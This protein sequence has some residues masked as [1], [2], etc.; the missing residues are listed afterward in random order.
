MLESFRQRLLRA[1]GS[2]RDLPSWREH[3]LQA[4]L[5]LMLSLGALVALPSMALAW[6]R[7]LYPVLL[8]D[9]LALLLVGG[10]RQARQLSFRTRAGGLLVLVHLLGTTLLWW[11][12]LVGQAYLMTVPVLAIL[13][14]SGRA[15]LMSLLANV[16]TWLFLG[17]AA[18]QGYGVL[19]LNLEDPAAF[20]VIALN[21]LL[22]DVLMVSAAAAMLH[23]LQVVLDEHH[24]A[25]NTFRLMAAQVPGV[26]FRLCIQGKERHFTYVSPGVERLYGLRPEEVLQDSQALERQ[27]HP[28]DRDGLQTVIASA[29][30]EMQPIA[31]EF[32]ILSR[33][34]QVKWVELTTAPPEE[35]PEGLVRMGLIIDVTER[36]RAEAALRESEARWKLA[37]ECAG[38]GVW[39]WDLVTGVEVF[40]DRFREM[41]GL[42][43]VSVP[44]LAAAMDERTHPDDRASMAQARADHL[45]GRTPSYVHEHRILCR[46]GSW[47][48]VLSRGMVIARDAQGRPLRMIG[49]H[50]DI[51][52][53]KQSEAVIWRQ[54]HFDTL[55]G[56]PNRHMLRLRLEEEVVRCLASGQTLALMLIDLDRFKEVNDTLGHGHGD[57]LLVE[58]AQRISRCVRQTDTVARMGGDEFTVLLPQV[59]TQAQIDDLAHRIIGRLREPFA[60]GAERVHVTAS[61]GIALA[62]ADAQTIDDLL[63][64]AD[65]A[66]YVAKDGG[67]NGFRYFTPALQ[68]VAQTRMRLAND[69]HDALP[70]HQLEVHYQPIVHLA[71]GTVR[72]AEALLRWHHP[73]R[74]MVSP[75]Q[76]IPIAEST[77]LI[78]DI[79]EW[80]F[81]QAMAQVA[82]WRAVHD[83][84]FN[85]SINKSPVQFRL[86][87][88]GDAWTAQLQQRGLPGDCM[89]VEITEGLLLDASQEVSQQLTQMRQAGM[90]VAMDDFG[91]GYSSLSY[92][93]RH[94][95]DILK[96]DQ[97]F[98]R[99]LGP[100]SPTLALCKAII[101]M[102][103]ELG[104]QVVAEGVETPTQ[105]DL[106]AEAGCDYGQGYLFARPMPAE[107]LDGWLRERQ[108]L[109]GSND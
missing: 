105:R 26:I 98:V 34:G 6:D 75:A 48:W 56:L 29:R 90:H 5:T 36:K 83:P 100:G 67:R 88:Q 73:S 18:F 35:T 15:A 33:D 53:R 104:M 108:G 19:H 66:L 81:Q 103:H 37:L 60:L 59:S 27:R 82:H 11:V 10:L 68:E 4:M 106:L 25:E 70:G 92:L 79:G 23:G 43:A 12:G 96:I 101:R 99:D 31:T 89:T 28:D 51:S 13:L 107:V 84:G 85:I 16:L 22:A 32:R 45:E 63:K 86:G 71:S 40:S 8:L 109:P 76:F 7:A 52:R 55:T 61:I 77:G 94:P 87:E 78:R 2:P 69:L 21:T 41:Y 80:V 46:D 9:V 62:P 64:H 17:L 3:V 50:T 20:T 91:T 30:R 49:T 97:A 93:H 72:K 57:L 39:D 102:A 47:K 58:A 14:L 24:R 44:D 54:A 1:M 38:D 42:D 65:Q 95:I 74:G